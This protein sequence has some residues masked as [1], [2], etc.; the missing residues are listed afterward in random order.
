M[1]ICSEL[2][3]NSFLKKYFSFLCMTALPCICVYITCVPS[4][5][6][7]KLP[8]LEFQ[9]VVHCH[10]GDNMG[11]LQEQPVLITAT[12]LRQLHTLF[13]VF[14]TWW[15]CCNIHSSNQ[16]GL[17]KNFIYL[18]PMAP[19]C[20]RNDSIYGLLNHY[21]WKA[22]G[23]ILTYLSVWYTQKNTFLQL[24]DFPCLNRGNVVH[25]EEIRRETVGL[26]YLRLNRK[27]CESRE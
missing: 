19:R 9:V 24:Q 10:V 25:Q 14:S 4:V 20:S 3:M 21:N 18:I 7:G 12:T 5:C 8:E 27:Y 22:T 15:S 13:D 6:G 2:P 26:H 16:E 1:G 23:V 11:P 17:F